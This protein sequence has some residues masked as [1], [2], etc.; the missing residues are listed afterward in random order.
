MKTYLDVE[1]LKVY[2][3]LCQLHIQVCDLTHRWP[4]EENMSLA[5]KL[6]VHQTV[7]PPSLLKKMMTGIY[8][9]K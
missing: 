8:E 9:I 6:D 2:H 7:L 1:D 3:K 5:A 4:V